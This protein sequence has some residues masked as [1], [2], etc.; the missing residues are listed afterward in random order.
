MISG[1]TDG[2]RQDFSTDL[3]LSVDPPTVSA[4]PLEEAAGETCFDDLYAEE[5][6]AHRRA[7]EQQE[8][9]RKEMEKAARADDS[10]QREEVERLKKEEQERV[11]LEQERLQRE[12]EE[13]LKGEE[14]ELV[15]HILYSELAVESSPLAAGSFKPVYRARWVRIDRDVAVLVLRNSDQAALSDMKNEIRIFWTLGK[16]KHLAELLAT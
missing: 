13:R 16:H 14:Q 10:L 9:V 1:V 7:E 15:R 2:V 5:K 6:A 4:P 11:R 3:E 8:D 12:E